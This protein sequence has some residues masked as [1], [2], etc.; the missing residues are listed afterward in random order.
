MIEIDGLDFAYDGRRVLHDIRLRLEKGTVTGLVGPNGAG[1]STLMRCIAGLEIPQCGVVRLNGMPVLDSPQASYAQMGYLPDIFGMPERLTVAQC[2]TFA[3]R[4]RGVADANVAME[5]VQTATLLNLREQLPRQTR[6]LS[7]GQRQRAGI[8][9]VMIHRPALLI[10][11][12]PA[13]GLDPAA[14]A[15]LSALFRRLHG[16]GMTLLV[17]SHILAE[18]DEYCTDMLVL[19]DG[20]VQRHS[21]LAGRADVHLDADARMPLLL[22]FAAPLDAAMLAAVREAPQLA[23]CRAEG[24]TVTATIVADPAVRVALIRHLVAHNVPLVGVEPL[25]ESLVASY[26]KHLAEEHQA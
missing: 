12:E 4:A 2:W 26:R 15:D 23:D 11:D 13:G 8:G 21:A 19:E 10:L 20:R 5:V 24:E 6:E 1:K 7:R 17:S 18:L 25:R 16:E 9:M 3:A 22:R 14:R